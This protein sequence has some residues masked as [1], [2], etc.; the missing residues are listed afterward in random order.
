MPPPPKPGPDAADVD[1]GF[2]ADAVY[3]RTLGRAR[4]F[5]AVVL[6]VQ[7]L[8]FYLYDYANYAAG[9]WEESAFYRYGVIWRGVSVVL[10]ALHLAADAVLRRRGGPL[11]AA[12]RALATLFPALVIALGTSQTVLNQLIVDDVSIY[13]LCVLTVA[14]LLHLPNRATWAYYPL[15]LAA[16][17]VG[18]RALNPDPAMW[19]GIATNAASV[20]AIAFV[21]ERL[22]YGSYLR[23][24]TYARALEGKNKELEAALEELKTAQDQLVHQEKLRSRP[25]SRTS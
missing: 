5:A 22:S 2:L 13:A 21:L 12:H 10:F 18:V 20:V 25:A 11:T 7:V 9:R 14:T 6:V 16:L 17:V 8:L 23:N 1:P 15:S 24:L 3:R 4:V 19:T